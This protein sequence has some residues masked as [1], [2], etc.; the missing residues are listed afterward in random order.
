M[1]GAASC[2]PV[3]WLRLERYALG[4]LDPAE[5]VTIAEHLSTCGRC[6]ARADLIAEDSSRELPPLPA[7]PTRPPAPAKRRYTAWLALALAGAAA[8]VLVIRAPGEEPPARRA[9]GRRQRGRGDHRA[10]PRARRL[11]RLG[12]N[13]FHPGRSLQAAAHLRPAPPCLRRPRRAPERRAGVPV[14]RIS[15][16]LWQPNPPRPRLPNHGIRRR[17]RLRRFRFRCAAVARP[18]RRQ[19]ARRIRPTRLRPPRSSPVNA[20]RRRPV[21]TLWESSIRGPAFWA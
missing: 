11:H 14:R 9:A 20:H 5:R 6:R 16:D 8:L 15:R 19:R 12:A 4:E 10:G 3:S 2:I 1:T 13:L 18:P 21:R 7:A 17:H